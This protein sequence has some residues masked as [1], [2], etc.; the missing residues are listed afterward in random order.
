MIV[1][2]ATEGQYEL[3]GQALDE[4]DSA[5]DALLDA[6]EAGDETA[7]ARE[8][9]RVLEIVRTR[10]RRLADDELKESD[11]VLPPPDTTLEEARGLFRD[12]PRNLVT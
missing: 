10:G 1:R 6:I 3:R 7:F 2:I 4:L 9:T 12:Y 8:L 5:D 11:L